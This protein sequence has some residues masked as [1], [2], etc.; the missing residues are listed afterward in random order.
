MPRD[1][2]RVLCEATVVRRIDGEN[3]G[4]SIAAAIGD[5]TFICHRKDLDR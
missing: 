2:S 1:G 4:A 3:G 5:Y